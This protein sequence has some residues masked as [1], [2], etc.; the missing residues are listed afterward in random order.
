MSHPVRVRGLKLIGREDAGI[1]AVAPRAGA[2]IETDVPEGVLT[3][4][5]VAPRA[6]AWIET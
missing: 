3:I 2:W 5:L 1:N 6:G 4:T